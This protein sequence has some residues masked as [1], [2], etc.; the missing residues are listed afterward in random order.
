MHTSYLALVLVC[1]IS[2]DRKGSSSPSNAIDLTKEG[3]GD[4]SKGI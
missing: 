2:F 4:L 1:D 3:I